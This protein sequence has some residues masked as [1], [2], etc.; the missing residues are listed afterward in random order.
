[1]THPAT[2]PALSGFE[3]C[4]PSTF[5]EGRLIRSMKCD[6]C[7]NTAAYTR[8]YSGESLCGE[9]F[10]ASIVRKTARTI[11]H[12][13]MIRRG[14]DVAVAV[15]GG[16]DS[17]SLLHVLHQLS[18]RGGY[19]IRAVTVDEGIPGYRDEAL[20][21]AR[22]YCSSLGVECSMTSYEELYGATLEET[23]GRT[24]GG[25]CSVCGV[26]RRRAI[27]HLARG[28]DV[29][30]TAH[31]MDDH[32]QTFLINLMS[33]DTSKIGRNASPKR[34]KPFCRIY[35]SEI[36]F[37]AFI[38]D[39]PF[40]T[41]PCPHADEGMR[42]D[43]RRFLNEMEERRSGIKNGMYRSIE[44]ISECVP[45]AKTLAPC[46]RCGEPATG[47][48]CSVCRTLDAADIPAPYTGGGPA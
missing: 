2:R 3:T 43:I 39:I 25:S 24:E 41:E 33:G 17:L 26:L 9:C 19:S 31:N 11:S 27:D 5:M 37:Y 23:L 13:N 38:N 18:G 8:R 47:G 16:K 30:A 12:H 34:I 29:V 1:M 45:D 42:T 7:E 36:V 14:D 46:G 20:E 44:R 40:Q 6:R 4:G 32:I 21:I 10:S 28:A 22:E 15:S 35:E 48:V